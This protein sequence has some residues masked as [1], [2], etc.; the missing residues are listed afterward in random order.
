MTATLTP[1][2][3][4]PREPTPAGPPPPRP[5][6]ARR[7][8]GA[9]TLGDR[10]LTAFF[11]AVPVAPDRNVRIEVRGTAR[12]RLLDEKGRELAR[13]TPAPFAP[14]AEPG[15]EQDLNPGKDTLSG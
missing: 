12:W 2:T 4:E 8:L 9:R 10:L 5:R 11:P 3:D 1:P 13:T 15:R 6:Q 14:G 7:R